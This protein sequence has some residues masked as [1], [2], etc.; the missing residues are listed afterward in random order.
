MGM[1]GILSDIGLKRCLTRWEI[2]IPYVI[3]RDQASFIGFKLYLL[4]I[5]YCDNKNPILPQDLIM[6]LKCREFKTM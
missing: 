1:M 5:K 2:E 4:F 3:L 6:V